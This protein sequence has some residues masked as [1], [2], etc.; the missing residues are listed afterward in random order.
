M[1]KVAAPA[2]GVACLAIGALVLAGC[3]SSHHET[4]EAKL[5]N[6]QLKIPGVT[7]HVPPPKPVAAS[8]SVTLSGFPRGAGSKRGSPNGSA[9][10]LIDVN[11]TTNELCWTFKQVKNIPHPTVAR[12]FRLGAIFS[13]QFVTSE[14]GIPLGHTY[15]PAGCIREDPRILG[16]VTS[17]PQQFYVNIH[18]AEYPVGAVR[19][20]LVG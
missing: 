6:E 3:G 15:T 7:K 12:L 17:K 16:L 18:D 13:R 11:P 8:Y 14:V 10:A 19:G 5:L 20:P 1:R 2:R 4:P 9:L